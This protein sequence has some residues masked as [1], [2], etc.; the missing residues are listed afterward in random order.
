MMDL[1]VRVPQHP[2][3]GET[4]FAHSFRTFVGGKGLNQAVAAKRAGAESVELIGCVGND[5]FGEEI[6]AYL[7]REGVG[8]RYL[9]TSHLSGTGVAVPIVY[10]DGGNSILS[11]PQANLA[12]TAEQVEAARPA[13][14]AADVMLIQLE[15]AI[16]AIAAAV[17]VAASA[18]VTTILN[19]API[20]PMPARVR[21]EPAVLVVNELEAEALTPEV[22]GDWA[23]RAR[24]LVSGQN[25]L[26]IITLGEQGA[27]AARAN[28]TI[29]T[30][31]AFPVAAID[32]VGAG[33]A[34]CGA[35]A[36]A[37]AEGG[38]IPVLLRFA[39]AA[40]ALATTKSGAAPSLP[41]RGQIER[42]LSIG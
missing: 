14:T 6:R 41:N 37:L 13:I 2:K 26:A 33:D 22:T 24:A 4:L 8:T 18:S 30:L 15:V 32:S 3:R 35:L 39:S 10:D 9:A 16:E 12:M 31:P 21:Q 36:V 27:V 23:D 40:G 1:V 19:A 28:G 34:F 17:A 20:A 29:T 7:E 38:D 11:V 42:L 25:G 5:A